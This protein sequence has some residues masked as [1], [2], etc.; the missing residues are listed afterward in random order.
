MDSSLFD[1]GPEEDRPVQKPEKTGGKPR[2][3]VPQRDQV[4]MHWL[5]LD[6]LLPANHAVRIIWSA[7]CG[8]DLSKWLGQIRAVEGNVGRDST[9]PRLL[10]ALWIY[11]ILEG[12]GSGR[13]LA[14]RCGTDLP[15]QW[16]CGKVSV[17]HHTLSDFRKDNGDAWD[18]LLTQIIASLMAEGLV[19]M[20][21]VAQ[22]GMRV[23][24]DAGSSSFRRKTKL[25]T[26]LDEAREQVETLKRLADESPDQLSERQR[27]AQE[28]AAAEQVARTEAALRH[29]EELQRQ[30]EEAAKKSGRPVNEARASTTDPEARNMKF[31]DGGYRPGYNVQFV[32]DVDSGLIVD[33]AVVNAGNDFEQAVPSLNNIQCRYGVVPEKLLVD[34]G[35]SSK[36]TIE[37]VTACGTVIYAPLK[38][39]DK[40][41]EAGKDPYARKR[42]DSPAMAAWRARM[43]TEEAKQIYGLRGQTAEWSNAQARNRGFS[44]MPVRGLQ[45][46][47]IVTRLFAI[48]H[49]IVT[50][51][52]L[53]AATAAA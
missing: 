50:A 12:I 24:A 32:T 40:Q 23:R 15:F 47:G 29:C 13:E 49:N 20:K 53:R 8:L 28:R 18:D 27:A 42:K 41:L 34:G 36:E 16:L 2:L 43:G 5:A 35:F 26:C 14:R 21:R 7:V 10:A 45:K 17:N 3:R 9:D 31:A 11:A 48:A 37:Q 33:A 19:T 22:D 6:E 38:D 52:R 4:E 30:R 1:L 51:V 46:C 25:E 39:E 44:R